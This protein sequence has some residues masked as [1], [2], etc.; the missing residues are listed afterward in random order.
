MLFS[1]P[2][3]QI[4]KGREAL[5]YFHN[6]SVGYQNYGLTFDGLLTKVSKGKPTIFLEG[7]GLAIESLDEG[8][9]FSFGTS[10]VKDAM[11]AL[12]RK[13]QGRIPTNYSDFFSA[14]SDEAMNYSF[15]DAAGF[16]GV[17]TA[18]VVG[19]G[20]VDVGDNVITTL[21]GLNFLFPIII[22]G[23]VAFIAYSKIRKA[24]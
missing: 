15:V 8:G 6:A 12:A 11:L 13:A 24:A 22:L 9:F 18:K 20:L 7:F 10:K 1:S 23:G 19:T 16:V 5:L 14:L 3:T 17:E 2:D 21:K 4:S